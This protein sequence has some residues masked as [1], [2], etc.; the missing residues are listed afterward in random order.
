MDLKRDDFVTPGVEKLLSASPLTVIRGGGGSVQ[1]VMLKRL[2]PSAMFDRLL[3][4]RFGLT[5][6]K[7]L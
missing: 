4:K 3:S 2:L 5:G 6:F 1:S 7:P